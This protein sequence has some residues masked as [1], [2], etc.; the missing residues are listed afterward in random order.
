MVFL[1]GQ[2][3]SGKTTAAKHLLRLCDRLI[4]IDPKA[5]MDETWDLEEAD[6]RQQ[7]AL[8]DGK[9]AR[10]HF[11]PPIDMEDNY[12]RNIFS[13]AM[14]AGN[15][16]LY[17]D[18]MY[19]V[20]PPGAKPADPL[21]M[22]WTRGREFGVGTW[23]ATQRPTWIPLFS[24]SESQHFFCFRLMLEDDRDR[25]ASLMGRDV[26]QPVPDEHGFWYRG[27]RDPAPKYFTQ[28]ELEL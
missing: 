3:G 14:D 23:G 19:A 16:I 6:V 20:F 22:T 27:V 1:A 9:A 26:Q 2:T 18:E 11:I 7:R 4:V 10:L 25:M 24:M 21:V 17:I 12:Y 8:L 15:V 28:M 13:L 5:N